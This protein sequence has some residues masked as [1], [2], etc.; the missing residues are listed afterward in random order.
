MEFTVSESDIFKY[1]VIQEDGEN[2]EDSTY[3]GKKLVERV[4]DNIFSGEYWLMFGILR[5]ALKKELPFS[6][7]MVQFFLRENIEAWI[8]ESEV[9]S[10]FEGR[11][12]NDA[13]K[14]QMLLE[15]MLMLY[16]DLCEEDTSQDEF[17]ENVEIYVNEFAT[18]ALTLIRVN[19]TKILTSGMQV[20]Q[21]FYKGIEDEREY[22]SKAERRVYDILDNNVLRITED[23]DSGDMT[24]KEVEERR[25]N[26]AQP[27]IGVTGIPDLDKDITGFKKK[28]YLVIQADTGVG[29]TR[30]GAHI[31]ENML[32]EYGQKVLMI[33]LEQPEMDIEAMLEA[34]HA[35]RVRDLGA[36]TDG[37]IRFNKL[38]EAERAV[39]IQATKSLLGLHKKN[40]GRHLIT[41]K[42]L[43]ALEF[44][45]YLDEVWDNGFHFDAVVID[46]FPL[47]GTGKDKYNELSLFAKD[48]TV[49]CKSYKGVGFFGLIMNQL[50][51]EGTEKLS[52]G[53]YDTLHKEGAET[54]YLNRGADNVLTLERTEDM[55]MSGKMRIHKSKT[56]MGGG[57]SY[58]EVD[59]LPGKCFIADI[60]E[61]DLDM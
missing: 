20:K 24:Y 2:R 21:R 10:I 59:Y 1:V 30:L 45:D 7:N 44:K 15:H 57:N 8:K 28:T 5:E 46:N 48:L 23:F 47:V 54:K 56:R 35:M 38:G 6:F 39:H 42:Y 4:K 22:T 61:D 13:E 25:R 11:E 43:N 18:E 34:R 53:K 16:N 12:L 50:T 14:Q 26:E 36:L 31:V 60:P 29:K 40:G 3:Y 41:S 27:V 32:A 37:N 52:K 49:L 19:G 55:K 33:S 17:K 9:Q 51:D 58:V